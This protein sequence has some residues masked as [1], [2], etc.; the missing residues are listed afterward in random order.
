MNELLK[1]RMVDQQTG[2]YFQLVGFRSQGSDDSGYH[3]VEITLYDVDT[4]KIILVSGRDLHR[5]TPIRDGN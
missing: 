3:V 4:R 5:L 1:I 2:K